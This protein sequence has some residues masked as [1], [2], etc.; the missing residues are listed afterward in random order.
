MLD[1]TKGH[2]AGI[3][4]QLVE[5]PA[6]QKRPPGSGT[7]MDVKRKQSV[8]SDALPVECHGLHRRMAEV[9]ALREKVASLEKVEKTR[10]RVKRANDLCRPR[11]VL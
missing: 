7:A 8:S 5:S 1:K 2:C 11:S 3:A 10:Q 9:L 6:A 4:V